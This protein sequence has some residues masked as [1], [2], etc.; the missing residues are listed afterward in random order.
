MLGV[1]CPE[2]LREEALHYYS[3]G[4]SSRNGKSLLLMAGNW[5]KRGAGHF[6]GLPAESIIRLNQA[7][8]QIVMHIH[9]EVVLDVPKTGRPGHVCDI[10]GQPI[11]WAPGLLWRRW[12][13]Y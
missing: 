4:Q 1:S 2:R 13:Y 11:P 8:Y 6:T 5:W 7:G 3:V 9:D 10:M 12:L